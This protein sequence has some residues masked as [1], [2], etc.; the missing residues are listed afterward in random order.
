MSSRVYSATCHKFNSTTRETSKPFWLFV[1]IMWSE[2]WGLFLNSTLEYLSNLMLQSLS[3]YFSPDL[4]LPYID[5]YEYITYIHVLLISSKEELQ[6]F[7]LL[8]IGVYSDWCIEQSPS[9]FNTWCMPRQAFCYKW[10]FFVCN[11]FAEISR[12]QVSSYWMQSFHFCLS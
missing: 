11:P 7:G 10:T 5:S 9:A 3:P 1:P 4:S 12:K 8:L 6:N 2:L